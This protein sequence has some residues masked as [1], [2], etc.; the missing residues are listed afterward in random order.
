MLGLDEDW[1]G[2]EKNILRQ[3]FMLDE[4][5]DVAAATAAAGLAMRQ[6]KAAW[7]QTETRRARTGEEH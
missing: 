3:S 6:L 4:K 2:L 7:A 5:S 1:S